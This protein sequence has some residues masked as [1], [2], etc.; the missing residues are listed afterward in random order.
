MMSLQ[1]ALRCLRV[2]EQEPACPPPVLVEEETDPWRLAAQSRLAE[3]QRTNPDSML[4]HLYELDSTAEDPMLLGLEFKAQTCTAPTFSY[5][6]W[7]RDCD[8]GP[9][10]SYQKRVVKLLQ[11]RRPPNRWLFK[12]P[13][14]CFHLEAICAA[15]PD[16]RFVITHRDPVKAIPSSASFTATLYTTGSLERVGTERLGRHLAEHQAIGMRRMIEARARIGE[17]RFIDIHQRDF[18][19]DPMA[20]IERVHAFADLGLDADTRAKMI[21]WS[22]E[23]RP[24]AFGKHKYTPEQFGLTS[25]GIRKQFEFYTDKYNIPLEA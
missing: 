9:A 24:G 19:A 7:W 18:V 23:N 15:Y 10:Y 25:A 21:A 13:H 5:H 12:A 22:Q 8:M 1:P 11:S 17:D 6:A 3:M 20:V 4:M 2:W 14:Y 16:A